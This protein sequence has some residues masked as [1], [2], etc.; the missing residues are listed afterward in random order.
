MVLFPFHSVPL[1][2]LLP[3]LYSHPFHP[4]AWALCRNSDGLILEM[5]CSVYLLLCPMHK[6]QSAVIGVKREKP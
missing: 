4:E 5:V 1:E 6:K 2:V 3:V